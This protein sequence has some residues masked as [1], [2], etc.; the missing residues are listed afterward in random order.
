MR[1]RSG[2]HGFTLVELLVVISIIALLVA[3]L[4][5]VLTQARQTANDV[6]C[7]ANM[8]QTLV[9]VMSYNADNP[10]GL[11]NLNPGSG[12]G[13][14]DSCPWF[15][16]PDM[17]SNN[18]GALPDWAAGPDSAIHQN[19]IPGWDVTYSHI[20]DE[21]RSLKSFWRG[22]LL[23][24]NYAISQALGCNANDFRNYP[25]N[26]WSGMP[27]NYVEQNPNQASL[28][29]TPPYQWWGPGC[30]GTYQGSVYTGSNF[31]ANNT[32][33]NVP[34]ARFDDSGPVRFLMNCP[35]VNLGADPAN[36]NYRLFTAPHRKVAWS[37]GSS[38]TL[39][40]DSFGPYIEH[41][42][43]CGFT[44]GSVR[45]VDNNPSGG[46]PA[47]SPTPTFTDYNSYYH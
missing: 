41:P 10:K 21:G 19:Y 32:W 17:W 1:P 12:P 25:I 31:G 23:A 33:T 44:D 4:L 43:N 27:V 16:T 35:T 45:F 24:G 18:Y 26:A 22:Y 7:G 37:A 42:V 13:A 29:Q 8:R 47:G 5:P 28:L 9:A 2:Q 34:L 40:F 36:I 14:G 15:N 6:R 20:W 39:F 3:M 30:M 46:N 11:K 38:G